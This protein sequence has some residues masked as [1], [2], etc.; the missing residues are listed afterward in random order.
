MKQSL[1][2]F[3]TKISAHLRKAVIE[4]LEINTEPVYSPRYVV[5]VNNLVELKK[6]FNWT[7]D[8]ILVD[9]D[10]FKYEQIVDVN[11]RRVRDAEA[12]ATVVRN[13]NPSVCLDIGTSKGHSAALMAVNAPQAKVHTVNIPPE[14]AIAGEG[15]KLITVALQRDEIGSYY[16]QQGLKNI[17]QILANTATWE[18]NIGD[19]DVALIDG[20]HDT[21][22]VF[23]DTVKVMKYMR[24]GSFIVWHDFNPNLVKS[25]SFNWISSVCA[26][27]DLLHEKG[28][29]R[30][31]I[32]HLKDSWMG[33]YKMP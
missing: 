3:Q 27:V 28:Y 24:S 25:R 31:P 20:C 15:G 7:L 33:I 5:E 21:E 17:E 32:Y 1:L 4:W 26:G 19:I 10:I 8:P 11:E 12:L 23:N 13:I 2:N 18:P 29:V 30:A 14:E 6:I 9:E 22:F 16:R